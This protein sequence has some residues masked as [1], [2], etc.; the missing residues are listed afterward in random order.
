MSKPNNGLSFLSICPFP[1]ARP[2]FVDSVLKHHYFQLFLQKLWSSKNTLQ[3]HYHSPGQVCYSI[4]SNSFWGLL[5]FVWWQLGSDACSG[6]G[7]PGSFWHCLGCGGWSNYDIWHWDF[8]SI[9]ELISDF[10]ASLLFRPK[11]TCPH[12]SHNLSLSICYRIYI[13]YIRQDIFLL[14]L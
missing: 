2:R 13:Y 3:L 6:T 5:S 9:T 12:E 11:V 7:L 8:R 10:F 14:P 4:S 1:G